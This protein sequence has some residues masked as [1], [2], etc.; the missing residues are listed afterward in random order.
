[1][2]KSLLFLASIISVTAFLIPSRADFEQIAVSTI[3]TNAATTTSARYQLDKP[4]SNSRYCFTNVQAS[5]YNA[6][7]ANT[8]IYTLAIVDGPLSSLTTNYI[9]DF[10]TG[11][12]TLTWPADYPLCLGVNT[13]AYFEIFGTSTAWKINGYGFVKK[14]RN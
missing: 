8:N 11:T 10:T 9:V 14:G 13:T 4:G 3:G 1:M 12:L 5:A 7:S 6:Y 2:K